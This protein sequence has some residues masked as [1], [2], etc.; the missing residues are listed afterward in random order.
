MNLRHILFYRKPRRKPR[1]KYRIKADT[2]D[3]ENN[4]ELRG[5]KKLTSPREEQ[6]RNNV[7][8]IDD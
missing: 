3:E 7:C 8:I 4:V 1:R 6:V 2:S 5:F